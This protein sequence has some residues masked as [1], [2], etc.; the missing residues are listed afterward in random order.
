MFGW[1]LSARVA[2][3]SAPVY[4]W[5]AKCTLFCTVAKNV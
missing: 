4:P 1:L 2:I 3:S 5:M